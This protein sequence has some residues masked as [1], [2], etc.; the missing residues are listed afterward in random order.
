MSENTSFAMPIFLA[1]ENYVKPE[2]IESDNHD[3]VLNGYNNTFWDYVIARYHGSPTNSAII[4]AYVDRIIGRGLTIINAEVNPSHLLEIFSIMSSEEVYKTVFDYVLF[5]S[6]VLQIRYGSGTKKVVAKVEHLERKMCAPSKRKKGVKKRFYISADWGKVYENPPKSYPAFGEGTNAQR[7]EILEIK[8][9][10]PGKKYY[11]DPGYMSGLQ[12]AMLE[13]EIANFAV[14][15]IKIGFSAGGMLVFKNGE[16]SEEVKEE[17]EKKVKQRF[18]GGT[19]AGQLILQFVNGSDEETKYVPFENNSDH[20][21][22]QLWQDI[23]R[24]QII[25]AHRV[26]NPILF[27]VKDSVGL[28]NN[29]NEMRESTQLLHETVIRPKQERIKAALYSVFLVNKITSPL[30]F[31]PLEDEQEEKEDPEK[32][33]VSPQM[34]VQLSS[35]HVQ[36]MKFADQ[37]IELGEDE[38][39]GWVC[40]IDEDVDYD[41]EDARDQM[42]HTLMTTTT[43]TARPNDKSEQDSE[44]FKV[45]YQYYPR[46]FTANSR[47]FCVKMITANKIYRKEDILRMGDQ[48]VNP[49][50]GPNGTDTYSIWLYKGGGGCHHKWRRRT[51]VKKD[52]DVDVN[53][54]LAE[55]ISTA[56]ARRRGDRTVNEPKVSMMPKDMPNNG[57]FQ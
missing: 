25:V 23:A 12:Y 38:D 34:E 24:Q 45:R 40:I 49:G 27:G 3:W 43:G 51:Y 30:R 28:G 50:W 44:L 19:N 17:L 53:S 20:Q 11:A 46:R 36:Q 29:A 26:T 48:V 14:N 42:L 41:Q 18:T 8:K 4:D 31:I 13:E 16:P 15:H 57:F 32:P 56:E 33:Q 6:A 54:P 2:I 21:D 5:G 10:S 37:L 35:H 52:G 55:L 39:E 47:P 1:R 9:Y 22:W 7:T